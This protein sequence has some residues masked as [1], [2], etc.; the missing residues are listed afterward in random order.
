MAAKDLFIEFSN[1]NF[2]SV[3]LEPYFKAQVLL[4]QNLQLDF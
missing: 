3:E 1:I 2:I 4:Q